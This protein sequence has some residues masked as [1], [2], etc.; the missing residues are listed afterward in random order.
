MKLLKSYSMFCS[1]GLRLFFVL[2][3]TALL[4]LQGLTLAFLGIDSAFLACEILN[5]SEIMLDH[6]IFG[7]SCSKGVQGLDYLKSSARGKR[8]LGYARKG[9][10]LSRFL[11][12]ALTLGGGAVMSLAH[13]ASAPELLIEPVRILYSMAGTMAASYG[14]TTLTLL[15]SRH[16][17]I[18]GYSMFAACVSSIVL[19]GLL[20]LQAAFPWTVLLTIILCV[21]LSRIAVKRVLGKLE[22]SYHDSIGS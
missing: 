11:V 3:I 22:E 2:M 18:L 14:L 15:I 16:W 17:T 21:P 6:W 4:M 13:R 20:W 19:A 5:T 8:V 12:G 10:C 9:D 1:R 7:G